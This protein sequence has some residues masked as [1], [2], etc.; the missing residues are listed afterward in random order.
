MNLPVDMER[1]KSRAMDGR[2]SVV[3][4]IPGLIVGDLGG[5]LELYSIRLAQA[6]DRRLFRVQMVCLWRFD[7]PVEQQWEAELRHDGIEV[8][9][10][11]PYNPRMTHAVVQSLTDLRALIKR[12]RP[13]IIHTHGEYAGVIGMGLRLT[14][15]SIP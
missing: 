9:Y 4:L 2:I 11:P 8:H 12:L 7:R 14:N 15:R 1:N 6:L 10:G 5:G 13:D 3:Q